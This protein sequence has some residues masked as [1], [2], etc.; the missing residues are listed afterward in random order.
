MNIQEYISSGVIES[1][2]LGLLSEEEKQAF[3]QMCRQ[4]P[5]IR[6]ALDEFELKLEKLIQENALVAPADTKQK[7]ADRLFPTSENKP[8]SDGAGYPASRASIPGF[9]W[10][11]WAAAALFILLASSIWWIV[12][13]QN[14]NKKLQT[15]LNESQR[16][17]E[18]TEQDARAL[19]SAHKIA[20]LSGTE[21]APRSAATVYWDTTSHDVY[22]LVNN[23]PAPA[24]GTQY[25]LWAL[26]DGKPIDMGVLEITQKP[27]QLYRMKNVQAAQ[28]FAITLE[29][30]GGS[31]TPT[32]EKM[33]VLGKL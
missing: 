24:S 22:L 14:E 21:I 7:I 33:Y 9:N 32:L 3:E 25:Q 15:S 27:L 1:Y 11:R 5:E 12:N 28:A 19:Q 4:Q 17:L 2:V 31:P 16:K 30:K 8:P 29:K 6:A 18:L 26:L 20:V 23:L 10:L 13:L